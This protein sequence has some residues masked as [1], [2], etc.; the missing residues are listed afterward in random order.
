MVRLPNISSGK[1]RPD[2]SAGYIQNNNLYELKLR[3]KLLQQQLSVLDA[4]C[5]RVA[6]VLEKKARAAG[7]R[8]GEYKP[9][10]DYKGC[11]NQE[12]DGARCEQVGRKRP[13]DRRRP[14]GTRVHEPP[15]P[16]VHV[17]PQAMT[18]PVGSP[19]L[20]P[21]AMV[22]RRRMHLLHDT[23]K[24]AEMAERRAKE[25]QRER[26]RPTP[27]MVGMER[28]PSNWKPVIC[29]IGDAINSLR[30]VGKRVWSMSMGLECHV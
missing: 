17:H 29:G 9:Q 24:K 27:Y 16:R 8:P 21:E 23:R 4:R 18:V 15:P 12:A 20:A 28:S 26:V 13:Q 14:F 1:D 19:A 30:C 22:E 11:S 5:Q 25:K 3:K 10:Q 6:G 2:L 7:A